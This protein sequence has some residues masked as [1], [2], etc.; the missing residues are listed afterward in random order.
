M[1]LRGVGGLIKP[2]QY[3]HMGNEGSWTNRHKTFIVAE[4]VN[5]Q[6]LLLYLRCMGEEEL[7]GN[8][9]WG[10]RLAENV[11]ILSF[12]R[13]CELLILFFKGGNFF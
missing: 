1:T 6:F 7:A 2:S 12:E 11:R 13:S 8:V 5:S 9:I 4:K 3:R 10:R